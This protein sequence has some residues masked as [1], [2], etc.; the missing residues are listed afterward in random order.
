MKRLVF[1]I[2]KVYFDQIVAGTKK[3]ELRKFSSFWRVRVRNLK[4]VGVC[5]GGS[6][7][8]EEVLGV[9]ICGK[10]IH[11]RKVIAIGMGNPKDFLERE[12]SDQGKA[13]VGDVCF[14]FYLGD[15]YIND[16]MPN[17]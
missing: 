3:V 10:R 15:E 12:L 1:R 7:I 6:L 2:R 4:S 13:D 5:G 11:R 9:F 17:L 8:M 14:A 16:N